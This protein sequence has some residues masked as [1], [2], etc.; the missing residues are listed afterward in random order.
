MR[1]PWQDKDNVPGPDD[2]PLDTYMEWYVAW[3]AVMLTGILVFV[4]L[5]YVSS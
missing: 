4:I 5:G 3:I 1:L 2:R